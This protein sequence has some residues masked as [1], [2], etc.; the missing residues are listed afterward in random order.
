MGVFHQ[1]LFRQFQCAVRISADGLDAAQEIKA[2]LL[3]PAG[4]GGFV[5]GVEGL[6]QPPL[7]EQGQPQIIVWLG[8]V[9]VGVFP[10]AAFQRLA[11][12]LLR[13]LK[14]PPAQQQGA[15]GVV[16]PDIPRVPLQPLQVVGVGAVGGVAVLLDVQAG[17]VQ[18]LT[19]HDVLRVLCR[20]GGLGQL[21]DLPL[22]RGIGQQLPAPIQVD[23][24]GKDGL[25]VL[26]HRDAGLAHHRKVWD[27]LVRL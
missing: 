14:L 16:E 12:I 18:L 9:G 1:A 11:E 15:V 22:Q 27:W 5:E 8:V 24:G 21:G 17:K 6:V 25:G 26:V 2:H 19:G 4:P 3:L 20:L 7:E 23:I 13:P 10:G